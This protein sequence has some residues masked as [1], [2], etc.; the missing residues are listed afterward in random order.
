[1]NI[2]GSKFKIIVHICAGL[3]LGGVIALVYLSSSQ[4]FRQFVEQKIEEQFERDYHA[5]MRA[6]LESIDWLSCKMTFCNVSI[7]PQLEHDEL[8]DPEWSIVAEK[9]QVHGSWLSLFWNGKLKVNLLFEH[10]IMM[11]TFEETPQKLLQFCSAMFGEAVNAPVVYDVIS[12]VDGLL[13][14]NRLS[15]HCCV[16]IP[17]HC[18]MRSEKLAT[19]MQ[20]YVHDGVVRVQDTTWVKNISGSMLSDIPFY[21][22]AKNLSAQVQLNYLFCKLEQEIPGFFA[23]KLDHGFGEFSL[24]SQ[25]GSLVVDPI[26]ITFTPT[27]CLCDVRI[28]ATSQILHYLQVPDVL[29]DVA[30][31]VDLVLH[32]DLLNVF[33]TLEM[34]LVLHDI[35]YKSKP[36]I[37]GGKI[38]I[39]DHNKQGF[40]GVFSMNDQ[41]KCMVEVV[42]DQEQ[43]KCK[44]FNLVDIELPF[45]SAYKILKNDCNVDL[46]YESSGIIHGQFRTMIRHELLL[47]TYLLQGCF[48]IKDGKVI[49]SGTFNDLSFECSFRLFPDYVF[50]S[51]VVYKD[52]TLLIDVGTD[53]SD[54][55]YVLGSVDFSV[56]HDLVPEIFKMSFAQEGSFVFKGYFKD[57][58]CGATVQ[59]H[60]AHIRV[61]YVYNVIQNIVASC[62]C[63][64]RE[65]TLVFKDIDIECY[66]G[67]ISC[68]SA[69]FY[70]D[71][72]LNCYFVHAPL[73]FHDV[74]LSWN[75]GI[76]GLVSGSILLEKRTIEKPLHVQGQLMLEK[77]ELKENIFSTEFQEL[78]SGAAAPVPIV[79]SMLQP[80]IDIALFTKDP[81]QINTSFLTAKALVD[82]CVK[83]LLNKTELSGSIKLL[84]GILNFPFKPLE[85][86]DGKILFIREQSVFDPMIEFVAKGK[87]KRFGVTVK[88]WGSALDP[89]L[90][91][92][93]QPYLSEEQ[94]ISLLLLGVEDQALSLMVP[95]FLTQKLKDIIFGPA[96][97]NVT[98]KTVFDRLLQSLKYV[99]FIPQFTNQTGRGGVRGIFEVDATEH[100]QGKIDTNF[101][102]LED[103]K[104]DI[105]YAATDDVTF[106]LQKDGPSTYGGQV[107][108]SWKFS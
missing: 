10:V 61:P 94:I 67:K 1:M 15:D 96:L 50:E 85:I 2:F 103:T 48:E 77:S 8:S 44:I 13:Y 23:G 45:D 27:Q 57:G 95:A 64:I 71:K 69:H 22:F 18:N 33:Q 43:K 7:T 86:I 25:D 83:G 40:S 78:L 41:Q 46:V 104:F 90:Q 87:L 74:M 63:N 76:F 5:N 55:S 39:T 82:V 56:L 52:K 91:F 4:T 89:H 80:Y 19:R 98:L 53:P 88:A 102:H 37:P 107:E 3:F 6:R 58:I 21:D 35:M 34:S 59:T 72:N 20:F 105:D 106:R 54:A 79:Q 30:G 29:S 9:L 68:G 31:H 65:K 47:Q 38:L 99:R 14:F 16:E 42:A 11:E 92:E 32:A 75:K 73:M 60:Y 24:K 26:K 66:E 36:L 93:S 62:E 108:L 17:Y 100:L 97:S 70:F 101:A 12:I 28:A 49:L 81:L 84:S 51:F